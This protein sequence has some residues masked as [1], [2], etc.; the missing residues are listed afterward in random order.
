MVGRAAILS[1]HLDA[2]A[3]TSAKSHKTGQ[4]EHLGRGKRLLPEMQSKCSERK[5]KTDSRIEGSLDWI[6]SQRTFKK[7]YRESNLCQEIL[8]SRHRAMGITFQ[9]RNLGLPSCADA[10]PLGVRITPQTRFFDSVWPDQA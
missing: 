8:Q 1:G 9:D 7:P 2:H 10:A 3:A 5:D 4:K 6:A